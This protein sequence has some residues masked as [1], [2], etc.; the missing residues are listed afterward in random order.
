MGNDPFRLIPFRCVEKRI[1]FLWDFPEKLRSHACFS[2][3][4]C[5][6]LTAFGWWANAWDAMCCQMSSSRS[7]SSSDVLVMDYTLLPVKCWL[8]ETTGLSLGQL[9]TL[10]FF[11]HPAMRGN[12]WGFDFACNLKWLNDE[13]SPQTSWKLHWKKPWN[14]YSNYD[15]EMFQR[16]ICFLQDQQIYPK[17]HGDTKHLTTPRL[18]LLMAEILHQL[19]R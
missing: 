9:K 14:R 2:W 8:L 5:C 16:N 12:S 7:S 3:V 19:I 1:N 15:I 11:N 13:A 18:L 10:P 17:T 6:F 4:A